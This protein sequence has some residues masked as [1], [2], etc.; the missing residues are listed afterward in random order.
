MP[1]VIGANGVE[2]VV[3]IALDASEKT[4]FDNSVKAVKGLM[5]AVVKLDPTLKLG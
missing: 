2:R 5:E 4:M 3:E 1:V